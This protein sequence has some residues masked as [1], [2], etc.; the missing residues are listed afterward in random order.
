MESFTGRR[1][2]FEGSIQDISYRSGD[3]FIQYRILN[4]IIVETNCKKIIAESTRKLDVREAQLPKKIEDKKSK[5]I[6]E[7][8]WAEL[9][10]AQHLIGEKMLCQL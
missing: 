10:Q 9:G 4:Q 5:K 8:S 7:T 3:T 6:I 1:C 2:G